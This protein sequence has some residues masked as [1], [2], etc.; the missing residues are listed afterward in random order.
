M[1]LIALIGALTYIYAIIGSSGKFLLCSNFFFPDFIFSYTS[2]L[3]LKSIFL[4]YDTTLIPSTFDIKN[5]HRHTNKL[6]I[7]LKDWFDLCACIV[8]SKAELPTIIK[9]HFYC[10][11]T[12]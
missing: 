6:N 2:G 4:T 9:I 11:I 7:K 5:F 8:N 1:P 10:I 3:K 12:A